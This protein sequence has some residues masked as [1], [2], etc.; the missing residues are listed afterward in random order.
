[1]AHANLFGQG[2]YLFYDLMILFTVIFM[3]AVLGVKKIYMY[4]SRAI[5]FGDSFPRAL[6]TANRL[7]TNLTSPSRFSGQPLT[8]QIPR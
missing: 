2:F 8:K 1:M 7:Y 6:I 4:L 5:Y 3:Y